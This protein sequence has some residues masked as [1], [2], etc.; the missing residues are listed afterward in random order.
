M[1]GRLLDEEAGGTRPIV[2]LCTAPASFKL[3]NAVN[4]HEEAQRGGAA[5]QEDRIEER[6]SRRRA[7][8]QNQLNPNIA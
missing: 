3:R 7:D 5:I 8:H 6:K 2:L 1:V 4:S